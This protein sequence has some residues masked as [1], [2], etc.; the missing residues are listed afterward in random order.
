MKMLKRP[1]LSSLFLLVC[2]IAVAATVSLAEEKRYLTGN[3][4]DVK[5]KLHGPALIFGGG[6]VDVD[7]ALQ[8]TINQVRGC[9]DCP[10]KLDLVVLRSSGEDG[11]NEPF[12]AL[13]GVDS[14]ETLLITNRDDSNS[15]AVRDT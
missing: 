9:E 3:R 6:N 7:T 10:I 15:P 13:K 14:V 11:Y 4:A 8:W 5:P 1:K 2:I 12:F